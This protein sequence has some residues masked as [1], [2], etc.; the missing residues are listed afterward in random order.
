MAATSARRPRVVVVGVGRLGS[1]LA[2]QLRK[3]GWPVTVRTQSPAGRRQARRLGLVE[4]DAAEATVPGR[5]VPAHGAGRGGGA[6]G[7]RRGPAARALDGAGPLRGRAHARGA[8]AGRGRT[9]DRLVPPAGLGHRAGDAARGALGRHRHAVPR[10]RAAARPA[11]R[12]RSGSGRSGSRRTA[13][14]RTTRARRWRRAGSC[15]CSTRRSPP[16]ARRASPEREALTALAALMRSA[17]AGAEARRHGGRA[18][19]PGR[20]RR[21]RGGAGAR[22]RPARRTSSPSTSRCSSGCSPMRRPGSPAPRW[23]G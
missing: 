2:V 5:A 10:A 20:P 11:G 21:R 13:A 8:A 14:R 9:A 17:L 23:P 15:R 18:D 12:R 3:A 22:P 7:A 4:A 19:R 6:G 16:G 1:A